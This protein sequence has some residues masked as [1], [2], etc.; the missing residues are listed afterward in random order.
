MTYR[1]DLSGC[2]VEQRQHLEF[3]SSLA[4]NCLFSNLSLGKN[5]QIL[6]TQL[7][8][9]GICSIGPLASIYPASFKEGI[10]T[11]V[12]NRINGV[13][14]MEDLVVIEGPNNVVHA[15]HSLDMTQEGISQTGTLTGAL[16]QSC[17]VGN[18]QIRRV[19]ARWVPDLAQEVLSHLISDELILRLYLNDPNGKDS[20]DRAK[21]HHVEITHTGSRKGEE[22]TYRGSGTTQR[23]SLG[24]MVQ[25][26]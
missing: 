6:L 25:N 22:L 20:P 24:S 4:H 16:D 18:L 26:G 9:D 5:I 10:L 23:A 19:L 15:I 13:I 2:L 8:L 12:A 17:D 21:I 14:H 1:L 7:A 3:S 11:Q